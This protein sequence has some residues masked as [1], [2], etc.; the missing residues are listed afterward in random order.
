MG[1]TVLGGWC[2]W[3]L[4]RCRC[5]EEAVT[6]QSSPVVV[7]GPVVAVPVGATVPDPVVVPELAHAGTLP[8]NK[9]PITRPTAL[10]RID[11]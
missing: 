9:A 1:L 7:P 4:R 2:L 8:T 11:T 6:G 5:A 10:V 3:C